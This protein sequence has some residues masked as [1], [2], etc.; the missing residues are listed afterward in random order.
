MRKHSPVFVFNSLN[1]K[2]GGLTKA[3]MRRANMLSNHYGDVQIL[4]LLYQR[5][6]RR[7]IHELRKLGQLNKKVTVKNCFTDLNPFKNE[8]PNSKYAANPK[9]KEKGLVEINDGSA[10]RYYKDGLYIKYKKFESNGQVSFIDYMN[11]S[12]HRTCREEYDEKGY[13]VRIRHY[14]LTKNKPRI[15]RYFSRSGKCF[16]T[17][18]VNPDSE[19]VGRCLLFY[20]KPVEFAN[21]TELY[22]YWV[23]QKLANIKKPALMS[24]SRFSPTDK[25]LL[26]IPSEKAKRIAILHNNHFKKP[27]TKDSDIRGS[28]QTLLDNHNKFDRVVFLTHEQKEDITERFGNSGGFRVIPHEAKSPYAK[29]SSTKVNPHLAVMMSRYNSQKRL[30]EAVRAFTHVVAEIPDARLEIYG[31]GDEE[32]KL[33][34]LIHKLNMESNIKLMGFTND[35]TATYQSAACTVL[36]SDYEGSPLVFNESMAAGT[37]I[38]TYDFKYGPKDVIRN[39][40]DGFVVPRGHQKA[41][42]DKIVKIMEDPTVR[43]KLSEGAVE[44]VERFSYEKYTDNWLNLFRELDK[45]D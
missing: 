16:L 7:N 37:P 26:N 25:I 22:S 33:K 40:I 24:D 43:A 44:I 20:P 41:L 39:G 27:Y 4:T 30:D 28:W 18:W 15:D 6:H 13:L 35:P 12:R 9:V 31:S 5:V 45:A 34:K 36:S 21:L 38:V 3:V 32:K 10:Y 42:A 14:D 23:N 1:V 2:R 29:R 17:T 8:K 11:E 19:Q